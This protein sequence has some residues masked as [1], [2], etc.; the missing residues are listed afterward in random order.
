MGNIL[1]NKLVQGSGFLVVA[2]MS[3]NILNYAFNALL[4]RY[5]SLDEFG[6]ITFLNALVYVLVFFLNA[7]NATAT[8]EVAYYS[9]KI[10]T[11]SGITF[12]RRTVDKAILISISA[13]L[14]FLFAIPVLETVFKVDPIILALISPIIVSSTLGSLFKGYLRGNLL[15]FLLGITALIDP[16]IKLISA[17]VLISVGL[18]EYVYLSIPISMLVA[19]LCT[20]VIVNYITLSKYRYPEKESEYT[21]NFPKR[22]YFQALINTVASSAFITFD[23]LLVR[24]FFTPQETGMYGLLSL[25]GKTIFFL[26]SISTSFILPFTSRNEGKNSKSN[27]IF[28]LILSSIVFVTFSC[29]GGLA[30]FG[31]YIVPFAFGAKAE[32]ILPFII[33]YSLAIS[34]FCISV[35]FLQHH[36]AKKNYLYSWIAVFMSVFMVIGFSLYHDS[37]SQVVNVLLFTSI[38]MLICMVLMHVVQMYG[39]YL[40]RALVDF[41]GLFL[42]FS[43]ENQQKTGKGVLIFNWRDTK[44]TYAGGAEEYLHQL[45]RRWVKEGYN[46]TWFAGNDGKCKRYE[47]LDGIEIIR[48]GGFYFVYIWAMLYYLFRFRGKYDVIIDSENG[49]PFFTPLYAKEKV[50]LVMHHVHREVFFKYLM[51]P[52]SWFAA[53][54]ELSVMPWAYRNT[55]FITVSKST[56]DEIMQHKLTDK[57]PILIHNGVDLSKFSPGEKHKNPLV[58]YLGRLKQYKSVDVLIRAAKIVLTTI[59]H[60]E[61]VIAGDGEEK[62]NLIKLVKDLKLEVNITFMGKVSEDQKKNLYQKAWLLVHPSM[63]EG[64]GIAIIEANAC[65]TPVVAADVPGLRDSVKNPHTGYLLRHGDHEGFAEKICLL[66]EDQKLRQDMSEYSVIWAKQFEWDTSARKSI[67]VFE[68]YT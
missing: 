12:L 18:D 20:V 35:A 39:L 41:F 14:I 43:S 28:Y 22:F 60:A 52:F 48:R 27:G 25:I 17:G 9:N 38:V 5:L 37:I 3:G 13:F 44:H 53:W 62:A 24:S 51:P 19:S 29:V 58:L 64:W 42:P 32:A 46:V 63:M 47:M 34:F 40:F 45:A 61:F 50:F 36:L 31:S 33:P 68:R 56:R 67:E 66:L 26:S 57:E 21:G 1:K 11:L 30:L 2:T 7:L 65:G 6:L 16:V 55:Q 23:I 15:F 10:S 54:L 8:R 4:G 59:P 49:I